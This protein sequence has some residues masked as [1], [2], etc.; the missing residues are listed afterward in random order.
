VR[1]PIRNF[2]ILGA[3]VL[4]LALVAVI[5]TVII[6][7]AVVQN[8]TAPRR[9]S[10]PPPSFTS[11][12]LA[13]VWHAGRTDQSDMLTI[14]SD[15]TYRQTVHI[16]FASTPTVDYQSP[17]Q[18]WWLES[19]ENEIP[20]LHLEGFRLCGFNPGVGCDSPFVGGHDFC[21]NKSIADA[22]EGILLVLGAPDEGKRNPR[23][24]LWLPAGS[25]NT[26]VYTLQ[27]P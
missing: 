18:H 27:M 26:W 20:Y 1:I 17:W 14:R 5:W 11:S 6:P 25:E 13:G 24:D 8:A 12:D 2:L 23:V 3:I 22:N 19:R 16:E 10:P 15:G 21:R 4:L 7:L 9:C